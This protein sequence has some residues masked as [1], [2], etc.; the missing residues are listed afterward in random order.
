MK[1][2]NKNFSVR[3]NTVE[4]MAHVCSYVCS[5]SFE[6]CSCTDISNY[7][8]FQ[9]V[10]YADVARAAI[11]ASKEAYYVQFTGIV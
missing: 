5:C 11:D 10:S 4:S 8:G 1:K 2:L 3:M 6:S 9:Y 7:A